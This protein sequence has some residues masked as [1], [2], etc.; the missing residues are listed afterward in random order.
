MGNRDSWYQKLSN[1]YC[2]L[3]GNDWERVGNDNTEHVL[4]HVIILPCIKVMQSQGSS[5]MFFFF[6]SVAY[7]DYLKFHVSFSCHTGFFKEL[8][9]SILTSLSCAQRGNKKRVGKVEAFVWFFFYCYV[10]EAYLVLSNK[11][12]LRFVVFFVR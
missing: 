7:L 3:N 4:K 8:T 2:A 10:S 12:V 6:K 5:A 11:V 9:L 1:T